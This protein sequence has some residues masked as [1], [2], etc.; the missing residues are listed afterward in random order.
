MSRSATLT[1]VAAL[2][3]EITEADDE[4][5]TAVAAA[6]SAGCTWEQI[7]GAMGISKQA[8]HSRYAKHLR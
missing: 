4:L 8:A 3:L 7:G 5:V 1:R 6:R 2:A